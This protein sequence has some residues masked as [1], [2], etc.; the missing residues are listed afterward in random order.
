MSRMMR[1]CVVLMVI[2]IIGAAMSTTAFADA[3]EQDSSEVSVLY[4]PASYE[5]ALSSHN[6]FFGLGMS[7]ELDSN[8]FEAA[9]CYLAAAE[10][11]T[12][13]G[14]ETSASN[15][16]RAGRNY[17]KCGALAA[18]WAHEESERLYYK[19]SDTLKAVEQR[20][21]ADIALEELTKH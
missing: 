1:N 3:T 4:E 14:I 18:V 21:M 5:Q 19:A 16:A 9:E 13:W 15:F 10:I 7:F 17:L 8:W 11:D 2:A 12:T 20:K 6:Y